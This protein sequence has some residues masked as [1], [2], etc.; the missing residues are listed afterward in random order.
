MCTAAEKRLEEL[1]VAGG[2][3]SH[4]LGAYESRAGQHDMAR[5][6]L[7]ALT[8][9]RVLIAEAETGIGKT[10][11]YLL[12]I[13]LSGKKTIISTATKTLQ[14]QIAAKDI[15]I[16][17]KTLRRPISTVILKG[18]KNYLCLRR[19][20]RF[21]AQ[22]TLA[23]PG[24]VTRLAE[25]EAW[26]T[27]TET[28]DRF[29]VTGLPDA[30]PLWDEI[31][32]STD[33]CLWM[34]CPHVGNCF[35][36][37]N[38]K[39]AQDA[40]IVITNHHFFFADLTLKTRAGFS[41]LPRLDA[42]IFDE[43]HHVAQI[44]TS[45]FG[46]SVSTYRIDGL[47]KDLIGELSGETRA[48]KK[49]LDHAFLMKKHA[50]VFFGAMSAEITG[51]RRVR[52]GKSFYRD[53]DIAHARK[54]K[55]S[56]MA[57]GAKIDE[58]F[59]GSEVASSFNRRCVEVADDLDFLLTMPDRD[60]VF[61]VEAK[62]RGTLL[63]ASPIRIDRE[64]ANTL[65]KNLDTIIF[66]SATLSISDSFDYFRAE[67]GIGYGATSQ[68][69]RSPFDLKNQALLFVPRSTPEP[70]SPGFVPAIAPLISDLLVASGG[71]ALVLFTSFKNMGEL[72]ESIGSNQPFSVMMQ[73]EAPKGELLRR[74]SDDVSSVLFATASFWE[75]VDIPGE[76]LSLVIIDK[77]PFDPPG[78]PLIDAR[79]EH[80]RENGINP[81]LDYQLPRAILALRQGFGRL[82]RSKNDRGVLAVLDSR[83]Y[84]KQYGRVVFENLS[85][86]AY[87]DDLGKIRH[88]FAN[89][90]KF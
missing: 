49:L 80:L 44:A 23:F 51:E 2:D 32:S 52:I 25:I 36:I 69:F 55:D 5:E 8:N 57:L 37:K 76:A 62:N 30:S 58:Y 45:Y 47:I 90:C 15:P 9:A 35:I 11:A 75:G 86:F 6:V 14:E 1:F 85:E 39:A 81:F 12:P 41:F 24:D 72:Y 20:E 64:L 38:R 66:T 65:F 28:G 10:I 61:W 68:R 19:F 4:A 88:F 78:E 27:K 17:E 77:L 29:E 34:N 70:G 21:R 50:D 82:I 89:E 48:V 3:L 13:L 46:V 22:G 84:T 71:R 87:T 7:R 54:L 67:L 33:N 60:F 63:S 26:A 31:N 56:V 59:Y 42:V 40:D 73:G 16:I 83:L 79:L 53:A 43:A 18:R 74:F